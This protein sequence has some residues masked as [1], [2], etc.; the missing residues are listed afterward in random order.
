MLQS[1]IILQ[2]ITK[3]PTSEHL[4]SI[5]SLQCSKLSLTATIADF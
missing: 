1:I 5:E 3:K 4:V 2:I